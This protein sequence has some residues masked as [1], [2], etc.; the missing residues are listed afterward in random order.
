MSNNFAGLE[1]NVTIGGIDYQATLDDDIRIRAH[2]LDAEFLE[3]A[4]KFSW[5]AM[6]AELAKDQMGRLKYELDQ[7][8][9]RLDC[10]SRA[11]AAANKV[12]KT[13][14]MVE[15]ECITSPEYQQAYQEFLEAKKHY[16]M[17]QAGREAFVQRKEM[18]ISL[19]AN[20]RAEGSADPVLLQ[21]KAKAKAAEQ[22]K[23]RA[24]QRQE[25]AA[26]KEAAKEAARRKA[27]EQGSGD[28]RTTERTPVRKPKRS[29]RKRAAS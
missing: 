14:K 16:G 1:V 4:R 13:E 6:V 2:D 10:K 9:A 24:Q 29:P 7:L 11:D 20:Y 25:E 19:G 5:W 26:R 8:Y 22:A 21:E 17:L 15:N 23:R 28:S 12:K 27:E 3:Q 18:L